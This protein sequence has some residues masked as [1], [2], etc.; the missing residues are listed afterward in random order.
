MSQPAGQSAG[1]AS[2]YRSPSN[3]GILPHLQ[4]NISRAW[5]S[6]LAAEQEGVDDRQERQSEEQQ[7]PSLPKLSQKPL[8]HWPKDPAAPSQLPQAAFLALAPVIP[9]L[10]PLDCPALTHTKSAV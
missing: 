8:K 2:T 1:A 3:H 9:G 5:I 4:P 7:C 10:W 6:W